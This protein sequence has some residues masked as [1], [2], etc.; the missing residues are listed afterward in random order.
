VA[1][2]LQRAARHVAS[3]TDLAQAYAVGRE[4][5]RYA[6]AGKTAVMAAIRRTSQS[7]YR[8]TVE[9][10]PLAKVA[11]HEKKMPRRYIST[12]GFHIT[13]ACRDYLSPLIAG[14]ATAPWKNGLPRYPQL[15]RVPVPRKLLDSFTI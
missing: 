8:W 7:P 15:K 11:N 1:D 14:E 6:V 10:V 5:V 13:Q 4:A 12:D 2:Y 3:A 9:P